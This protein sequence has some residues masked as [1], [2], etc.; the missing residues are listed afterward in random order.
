MPSQGTAAASSHVASSIK[1]IKVIKSVKKKKNENEDEKLNLLIKK[2]QNYITDNKVPEA[3]SNPDEPIVNLIE[4]DAKSLKIQYLERE[5][6]WLQAK[7]TTLEQLL[8]EHS[9]LIAVIYGKLRNVSQASQGDI[10]G[11]ERSSIV[12]QQ[13]APVSSTQS[14]IQMLQKTIET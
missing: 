7:M 3:Q 14:D 13:P 10:M 4:Y 8:A 12:E 1:K 6:K 11:V 2:T 9:Q 5:N